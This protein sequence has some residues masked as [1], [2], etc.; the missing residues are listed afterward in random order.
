M[1]IFLMHSSRETTE[2]GV[3]LGRA[4]LEKRPAGGAGAKRPAAAVWALRG[5]LGAGKTTFV[6]GFARGL[7]I[8]RRVV[9]PT[10]VLMRRFAISRRGIQ[11]KN[12]Y[13]I[14][15][16]RI[17]T[18][19]G[20]DALGLREIFA[21]PQAVVLIEWPEKLK[22]ILPRGAAKVSFRHGK[23]E[24]ERVISLFA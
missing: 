16:Y 8:R 21:D 11:F 19:D 3:R 13:H 4:M 12:L 7:G 17:K 15:A 20:L 22:K 24:N 1:Q 14:D 6:Q 9:S 10:F 2:L 18:T 5:D 23:K